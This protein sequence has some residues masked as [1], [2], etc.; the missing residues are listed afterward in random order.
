LSARAANSRRS[1]KRAA[2]RSSCRSPATPVV[3]GDSL[4]TFFPQSRKVTSARVG[5]TF[6]ATGLTGRMPSVG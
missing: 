4:R 1:W 2:E 5:R 6:K 3:R